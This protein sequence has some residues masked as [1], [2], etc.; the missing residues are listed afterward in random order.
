MKINF[1][2]SF[3]LV[4]SACGIKR[5]NNAPQSIYYFYLG[6]KREGGI[7]LAKDGTYHTLSRSYFSDGV[8]RIDKDTLYL[9]S[10]YNE[11]SLMFSNLQFS[12]ID[13]ASTDS[14]RIFLTTR[15][16]SALL[17]YQIELLDG[18]SNVMDLIY[19]PRSNSRI[20]V[21][22]FEKRDVAQIRTSYYGAKSSE[23]Y[24]SDSLNT[25]HLEIDYPSRP[26]SYHFFKDEKFL[27]VGD[28]LKRMND[29]GD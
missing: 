15:D 2:L 19:A 12:N 22:V 26:R 29:I 16:S 28:S 27:M 18:L 20:A 7:A 3:L 25:L 14:V 11:D 9:T 21:L 8:Y 1:I 5:L 17:Y 13:S 10:R 23:I 24:L 6:N 4:L